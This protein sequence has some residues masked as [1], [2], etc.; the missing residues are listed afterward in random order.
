M[1]CVDIRPPTENDLYV[2]DTLRRTRRFL[3]GL[4]YQSVEMLTALLL[5][6][7]TVVHTLE[8]EGL[9]CLSARHML[10]DLRELEKLKFVRRINNVE[11]IR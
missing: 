5:E 11:T 10:L 9:T 4:D 8:A 1:D 3:S 7:T 6:L 2:P